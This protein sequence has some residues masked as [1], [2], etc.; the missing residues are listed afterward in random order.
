MPSD[1]NVKLKENLRDNFKETGKDILKDNNMLMRALAK[2]LK[3]NDFAD[4]YP[5]LR[6]LRAIINKA[7]GEYYKLFSKTEVDFRKYADISKE[8]ASTLNK[9]MIQA[10]KAGF[11]MSDEL[12][13]KQ[14]YS[15]AMIDAYH[16]YRDVVNSTFK[17]G[18]ISDANLRLTGKQLED[19]LKT[20]DSFME[21]AKIATNKKNLKRL[22]NEDI[23][24]SRDER[25][26]QLQ[27]A[28][29]YKVGW[30]ER[31]RGNGGFKV[32]VRDDNG[33][34]LY[35][36]HVDISDLALK[37]GAIKAEALKGAESSL[38]EQIENKTS[39]LKTILEANNK[40][41]ITATKEMKE[42]LAKRNENI[43]KELDKQN[44][45]KVNSDSLKIERIEKSIEDKKDLYA[46][47]N[48]L[49]S[50]KK[51]KLEEEIQRINEKKSLTEAQKKKEIEEATNNINS[52]IDPYIDGL[53]KEADAKSFSTRHTIQRQDN[54]GGMKEDVNAMREGLMNYRHQSAKSNTNIKIASEAYEAIKEIK[55]PFLK[56]QGNEQLNEFMRVAT[57]FERNA[58]KV[59]AASSV[60]QFFGIAKVAI[61]NKLLNFS[62][63][64]AVV[65]EKGFGIAE[66]HK[67]TAKA[68]YTAGKIMA[69]YIKELRTKDKNGELVYKSFSDFINNS[70]N[71]FGLDKNALDLLKASV[72]NG[73]TL[74]VL[75][76]EFQDI[77]K[78]SGML[79]K[80]YNIGMMPMT[81]SERINRLSSILT[82]ADMIKRTNGGVLK[83]AIDKQY[84]GEGA[85]TLDTSLAF[86]EHISERVNGAYGAANRSGMER[87]SGGLAVGIRTVF[88]FQTYVSHQLLGLYP[89]YAMDTASAAME[90]VRRA[91]NAGTMSDAEFKDAVSGFKAFI[92]M[93]SYMGLT[94]GAMS[95]PFFAAI[96]E[97]QKLFG[98]EP[99]V[100]DT[101]KAKDDF[102]SE[103]L[104][105]GLPKA[106]A[107]IDLS[108]SAEANLP[109][110][111]GSY[112]KNVWSQSD[113]MKQFAMGNV[114]KGIADNFMTPV[115]V[116][117]IDSAIYDTDLLTKS[118]GSQ[119][120][121]GV[122]LQ[123]STA[124]SISKAILGTQSAHISE[125]KQK[126][127]ISKT[128][129]KWVS[130]NKKELNEEYNLGTL[131]DEEITRFQ[132]RINVLNDSFGKNYSFEPKEEDTKDVTINI[133]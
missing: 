122:D 104:S 125:E 37:R 107:G 72:N 66:S 126:L 51:Q 9:D 12:M 78:A 65:A 71:T 43:S 14:G 130:D 17:D 16:G 23:N 4:R 50:L 97:Y 84:I 61:V 128:L 102:M 96:N 19:G 54:I 64:L 63:E 79:G 46:S 117:D 44:S 76:K 67:M 24:L 25:I 42:K 47:A 100:F 53:K 22:I 62:N 75:T 118:G 48:E 132:D 87:G 31:F 106:M 121:N 8:E 7:Q 40:K 81:F 52:S 70:K 90:R 3:A 95:I 114:H 93:N 68:N 6:P 45:R 60:R 116:K 18:L 13:K 89:K 39:N 98:D 94:G 32:V 29:G 49:A 110:L 5:V 88:P 91:N 77:G 33:K 120:I 127:Y 92:L 123:R 11:L 10:D 2:I 26:A 57:G 36:T 20:I 58:N 124:E 21:K 129:D 111:S 82:T 86:A 101:Q 83:D 131:E 27:I 113:T 15:Q 69:Q 38:R 55:N 103:L 112:I 1:C 74:D 80:I 119:S 28:N 133:Q 41:M 99:T 115:F 34:M 108:G 59:A 105:G 35:R 73:V 30:V 85:T 109:Y 56:K